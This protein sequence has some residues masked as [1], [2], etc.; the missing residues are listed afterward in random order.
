MVSAN[1]CVAKDPQY[2]SATSVIAFHFVPKNV[3]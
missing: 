3:C 2:M 1:V